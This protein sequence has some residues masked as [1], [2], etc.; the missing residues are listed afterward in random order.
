VAAGRGE[1]N[2]VDV[3]WVGATGMG[4]CRPPGLEFDGELAP[5]G[6]MCGF[7]WAGWGAHMSSD[8]FPPAG[9]PLTAPFSRIRSSSHLLRFS[10]SFA[11]LA[12]GLF[13]VEANTDC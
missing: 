10:C 12:T 6:G 1:A 4:M 8:W 3:G 7:E 13:R 9:Q 5:L 11:L 2:K